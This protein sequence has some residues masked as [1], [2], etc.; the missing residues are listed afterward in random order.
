MNHKDHV[1]LIE[2]CVSPSGGIWADL[3]SGEGA[4]TLA[5]ADITHSKA[6]IYSVDSDDVA[7]EIQQEQFEK[8]FPET[9]V[10]YVVQDFTRPLNL[11]KLDGIIMANSLHYIEDKYAFLTSLKNYLKPDGRLVIVE[12]NVDVG[13]HWVP[14]AISYR[15]FEQLAKEAGYKNTKQLGSVPSDFLNEI[16]SAV[17]EV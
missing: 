8:L 15:S 11:P 6:E 2:E 9:S 7:L 3:G 17:T 12:Y 10:H 13:N 16:Y 1:R 5:L 4:F 14:Y